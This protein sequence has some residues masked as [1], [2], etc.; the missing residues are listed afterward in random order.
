RMLAFCI[1]NYESVQ[2]LGMTNS[3][4]HPP[5]VDF[6]C[7]DAERKHSLTQV[8]QQVSDSLATRD[9]LILFTRRPCAPGHGSF[10]YDSLE[11]NMEHPLS[12][13]L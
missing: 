9:M 10:A 8:K 1:H 3:A 6:V 7:V 12:F 5:F 13:P 4:R 2:R 11:P